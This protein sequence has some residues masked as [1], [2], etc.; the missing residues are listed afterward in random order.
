MEE[1]Y[2]IVVGG[3]I[4]ESFADGKKQRNLL[5][6]IEDNSWNLH[7]PRYSNSGH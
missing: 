2:V 7:Y 1:Y 5:K 6:I 3:G 4:A